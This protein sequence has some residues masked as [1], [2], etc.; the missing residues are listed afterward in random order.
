MLKF[1]TLKKKLQNVKIGKRKAKEV[2]NAEPLI[3]E[4]PTASQV[5]EEEDVLKCQPFTYKDILFRVLCN[6]QDEEI[7]NIETFQ[8]MKNIF[9]ITKIEDEKIL[10][11]VKEELRVYKYESIV[12]HSLL[13]LE[14][15]KYDLDKSKPRRYS[16]L[17]ILNPQTSTVINSHAKFKH[18]NKTEFAFAK[19]TTFNE[20]STT[21]SL[22]PSIIDEV[23]DSVTTD[24]PETNIFQLK[25]EI[26]GVA[27]DFWKYS[28]TF[29][30]SCLGF[31][32]NLPSEEKLEAKQNEEILMSFFEA[33]NKLQKCNTPVGDFLVNKNFG[34]LIKESLALGVNKCLLE[35]GEKK[36]FQEEKKVSKITNIVVMALERYQNFV[37]QHGNSF[38]A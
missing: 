23:I 18:L 21:Y 3:E 5:E 35:D 25:T 31:L 36:D 1:G 14:V 9:A 33:V 15:M 8:F 26:E 24:D 37:E 2:F 28:E 12:E 38:K 7:D 6:F 20:I 16:K 17:D 11:E 30:K 4:Q 29:M 10:E 27:E 34:E 22:H 13:M 32:E 19:W